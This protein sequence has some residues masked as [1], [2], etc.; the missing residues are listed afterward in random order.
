MKAGKHQREDERMGVSGDFWKDLDTREID[1]R[2]AQLQA[3]AGQ[4]A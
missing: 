1:H 2:Y 3:Y 4:V